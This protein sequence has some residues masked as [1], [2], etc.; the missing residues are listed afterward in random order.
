[1]EPQ[2]NLLADFF[3]LV[4]FGDVGSSYIVETQ[5]KGKTGLMPLFKKVLSKFLANPSDKS[6]LPS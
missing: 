6:N 2:G 5:Y 1:M 3:I 4:K